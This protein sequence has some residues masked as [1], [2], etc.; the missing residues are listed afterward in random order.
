[1]CNNN[2]QNNNN[3]QKP[4][5]PVVKVKP[6]KPELVYLKENFTLD[7]SEKKKEKNRE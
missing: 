7:N 2:N 6:T 1:M 3:A 4:E 5:E